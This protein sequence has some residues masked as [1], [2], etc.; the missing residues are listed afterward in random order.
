MLFSP[1]NLRNKVPPTVLN[2]LRKAAAPVTGRH[3]ILPFTEDTVHSNPAHNHHSLH[4]K[5]FVKNSA[6]VHQRFAAEYAK[7]YPL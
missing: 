2:H 1:H 5:E 6:F 7:Q 4:V 3:E